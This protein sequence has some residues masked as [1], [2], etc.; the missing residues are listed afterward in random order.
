MIG[1]L[2]ASL[3]DI[4]LEP[5]AMERKIAAILAADVVG[6]S[7]LMAENEADTFTRLQAHRKELF[8]PE[9]AKHHGRIFKLMGD[10][11]LAEFGSVVDAV[12]CAVTVQRGM[13]ERNANVGEDQRIEMRIGIN[14]GDVIVEGEDRHG[15]GV[16]IAARLQ[17]L[18]DPGGILMAGTAYDH[19]RNKLT[20]SFED[21]GMPTLKNLKDPVRVYRVA[22]DGPNRQLTAEHAVR[23]LPLPK[24]PSI[25]VLPLEN[26]SGD[27]D[28]QY[29]S[30][31][32]TEDVITELARFRQLFVI[33][34][35]S[36]FQYRGKAVDVKRIG[37]ELGV[38]YVVEGSVRKI[39]SRVRITAQLV[40]TFTGNHL[41]AERYDRG[42]E[43]IF[44]LQD[45]V[46]R[47]IV[48]TLVGRV[49]AASAEHA[50][51]K[52]PTN[53]LAYDYVLR[54]HALPIGSPKDEEEA[55]R[56][57]EKAIEIDP[58]YGLAHAL[59]VTTLMQAWFRDMSRSAEALDEILETAKKAVALDADECV[60]H[61]VLGWVHL[62]R[63]SYNLAEAHYQRG[64]E[65]N[66][67]KPVVLAHMC[68][69]LTFLG[70]SEE[71]ID[72]L[73]RARRLDPYHPGWY[74]RCLGRALF[75]GRRYEEAIAAF[76]R[77][78]LVPPWAHVYIAACH[79]F[80]QR[81]ALAKEA[82]DAAVQQLA[83]FSLTKF[84]AKEPFKNPADLEHLLDGLRQ[85][86]L[87]E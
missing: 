29:F 36:S 70:R 33:A 32:I 12:E 87:P 66:P 8:E 64:L 25:A 20:C 2:F 7:R 16:N 23:T 48:G 35:N 5:L 1:M 57:F 30:D 74:W 14:L 10:G 22:V 69:L 28:Q 76:N 21:L 65:L 41:W 39:G 50:K 56:M 31:G 26:L 80:L 27:R 24:K 47:T 42:L 6:Y 4:R 9:I 77:P 38:E 67:N 40:D 59:L 15:E 73:E 71:A 55:R 62:H 63:R 19:V 18:A 83:D 51:R 61:L 13:A 34:R 37:R 53:M 75:V 81:M 52:Q 44:T 49:Q 3:F 54:G 84:A 60:C 72:W 86:G 17:E 79:A 78:T 82:A 85:A 68:E 11:L 45:E 43:E 46:V 58:E